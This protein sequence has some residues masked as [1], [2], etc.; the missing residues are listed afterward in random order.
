MEEI[1][2]LIE[3]RNSY[4]T[5]PFVDAHNANIA[6]QHLVDKLETRC[7][8]YSKQI[9]QLTTEGPADGGDGRKIISKKEAELRDRIE[10]LQEQLNEKLS[11]WY[12]I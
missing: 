2:R 6:L 10:T 7:E 3:A 1:L 9:L 5:Y 4:E 8:E 12:F 11:K